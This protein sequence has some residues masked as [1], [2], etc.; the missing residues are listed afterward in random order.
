[1]QGLAGVVI[2]AML[3]CQRPADD[4]PT[5]S[6][7]VPADSF[8]VLVLPRDTTEIQQEIGAAVQARAVAG[9][10]RRQA[11][12]LRDGTKQRIEVKEQQIDAL[13]DQLDLAEK[14]KRDADRARA[15]SERRAAEREK[16]LLERRAS[17]REAE[18]D[19]A[20]QEVER[21][22]LRR[23]ALELELQLALQRTARSR[24]TP[25]S[26]EAAS[27]DR[28]IADLERQTLEAQRAHAARAGDVA[29]HEEEVVERLLAI[30][31]AQQ[32]VVTG[33]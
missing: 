12:G 26:P 28:I 33:R 10:A 8:L 23:K 14:E 31:E 6:S 9:H 2:L 16:D 4:I 17:L 32:K 21:A 1:M 11:E 3:S 20:R 18:I 25:G 13:E 27:L 5:V 15:E 7:T 24:A 30:L 29:D 22:E 19:L